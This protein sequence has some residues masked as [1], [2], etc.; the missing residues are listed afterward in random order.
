MLFCWHTTL[1]NFG[2]P[3]QT[4]N[5]EGTAPGALKLY[6]PCNDLEASLTY[7]LQKY[8]LGIVEDVIVGK[9]EIFR[10]LRVEN[11]WLPTCHPAMNLS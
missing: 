9:I 4:S 5:E 3:V 1:A 10:R 7:G 2:V 6:I 11:L 8:H